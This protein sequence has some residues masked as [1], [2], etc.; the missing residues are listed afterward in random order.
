[1][2]L[3]LCFFICEFLLLAFLYLHLWSYII[4]IHCNINVVLFFLCHYF[5]G[6]QQQ[7]RCFI[8]VCS[9]WCWMY[10]I[11]GHVKHS[12]SLHRL[13]LGCVSVQIYSAEVREG[14]TVR[15]GN[16]IQRD[17]VGRV[18]PNDWCIWQLRHTEVLWVWNERA[19]A[20]VGAAH[21]WPRD[22]TVSADVWLSHCPEGAGEHSI[23]NAGTVK[24]VV[25]KLIDML[26]D[27]WIPQMCPLVAN[28]ELT[29]V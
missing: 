24:S 1:M 12:P 17:L 25:L 9:V 7:C 6:K 11:Y 18:Q 19:E 15:E 2:D 10:L 27:M 14:I 28:G 13:V 3:G 29:F 20:D 5:C 16:G 4:E 23:W 26:I 22:A 21:T 8:R